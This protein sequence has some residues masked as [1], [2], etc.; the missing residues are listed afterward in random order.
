MGK[1]PG[2][3]K[4]EVAWDLRP[5]HLMW[6]ENVCKQCG[7]SSVDKTMRILLDFY[8]SYAKKVHVCMC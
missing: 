8:M 6:L 7:H 5:P 3:E 4:V 2:G 1:P